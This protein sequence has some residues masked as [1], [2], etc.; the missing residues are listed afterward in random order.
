MRSID[1]K[2]MTKSHGRN[3]QRGRETL[4]DVQNENNETIK[5][6]GTVTTMTM[7]ATEGNE[8]DENKGR[9]KEGDAR[10]MRRRTKNAH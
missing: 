5:M 1:S 2:G 10:V 3:E 4:K 8:W 9:G 7:T 6:Y